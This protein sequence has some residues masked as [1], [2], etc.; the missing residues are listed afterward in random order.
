MEKSEAGSIQEILKDVKKAS[1]IH[2]KIASKS[3]TDRYKNDLKT[4]TEN[5]KIS[6]TE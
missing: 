1:K 2:F 4:L 6:A 5:K 3:K